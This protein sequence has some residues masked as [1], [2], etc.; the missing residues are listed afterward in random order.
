MTIF[1][2][3]NKIV[4]LL[5]QA[6]IARQFGI[7]PDIDA[8]NISNNIPDLIFSVISGGALALAFIPVL[9]EYFDQ[10]G[11]RAAWKLFSQIANLVF[12]TTAILSIVVILFAPSIIGS[13]FGVAPGFSQGQQLLTTRLMS[14]NLIATLIFSLSGL[15]M[16]A[17]QSKKHFLLPAI[18]PILYNVGQIIGALVLTPFFH[19]GVYGLA[20]GVVLGLR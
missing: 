13:R 8:F 15:V 4:A 1:F 19:R 12:F 16:A 9:T 18:A 7:T 10:K 5:R 14:I 3:V 6:L 11:T 17:L 20:Y 2:G